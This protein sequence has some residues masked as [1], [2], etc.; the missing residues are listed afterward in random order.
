MRS[1]VVGT[2]KEHAVEHEFEVSC[3]VEKLWRKL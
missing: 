2:G 1:P 3:S